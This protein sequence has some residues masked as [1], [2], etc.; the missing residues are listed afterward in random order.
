M[1]KIVLNSQKRASEEKVSHLRKSRIVPATVYGTKQEAISIKLGASDALRAFRKAWESQIVTLDVEGKKIDVLFHEV[2]HAPVSWDI[3]HIDFLAIVAGEAVTTNIPLEFIGESKAK[4]EEA[5]ILEEVL[6]Q[7]EVKC[8][9]KDLVNSFEVDL[10]LIAKTGDNIKVSDL[11]IDTAKYEILTL[12]DEI[13]VTSSKSRIA[14]VESNA[15][16]SA[17]EESE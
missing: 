15:Q 6:K 1:E 7:I 4:V 2:Q 14:A 8:L 13:V 5:A 16:E 9:P 3:N 12:A 11:G 17:T 10:S